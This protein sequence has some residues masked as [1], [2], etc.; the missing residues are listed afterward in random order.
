MEMQDSLYK[1]YWEFQDDES[2]ALSQTQELSDYGTLCDMP[3]K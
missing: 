2:R 3:M 1:H